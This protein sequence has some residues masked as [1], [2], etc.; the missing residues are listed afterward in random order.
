MCFKAAVLIA[1]QVMSCACRTLSL[2][3]PPLLVFLRTIISLCKYTQMTCK[4]KKKKN[5]ASGNASSPL[6]LSPF[7]PSPLL[8]NSLPFT[9]FSTSNSL[10]LDLKKLGPVVAE[11]MR[12]D[13]EVEKVNFKGYGR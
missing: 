9:S 5:E 4:K 6:F 3:L 10:T 2:C 7:P 13:V 12:F 11:L 1:F 8:F